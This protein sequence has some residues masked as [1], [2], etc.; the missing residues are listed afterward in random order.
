MTDHAPQ[1]AMYERYWEQDA[2]PL[3]DALAPERRRILWSLAGH[4]GGG[5]TLVDVGAGDGS[6][7]ADATDRGYEASGLEISATAI[8]H[9]AA[10][11]PNARLIQHAVE[12]RPWPIAAGTADVVVSFEVIE[13]LLVPRDLASGAFAALRP[14]GHL[15]LTTPYHGLVKNLAL[16]IAGFDRHFD[17]IGEHI[18]FF[19]DRSLRRLLVEEGFEVERIVHYG[20]APLIWAGSFVWARRPT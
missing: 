6:L 4:D 13:H 5:R 18:R 3:H 17:P 16:A 2:P 7:V 1:R 20:R 9:A 8:A 19:T 10:T 12:Q 11:H 15:A 14:A